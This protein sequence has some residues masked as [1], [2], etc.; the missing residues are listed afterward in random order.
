MTQRTDDLVRVATGPLPQVEVWREVLADRG[1]ACRVVGDHLA[2]GLGTALPGSIELWVHRADAAAAEAA[3]AGTHRR[4]RAA[5]SGPA[6]G[7]P[8]S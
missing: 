5:G 2:T 3:I 1:V 4:G 8:I 6:P 7:L